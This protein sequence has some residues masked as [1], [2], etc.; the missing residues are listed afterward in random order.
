MSN[1]VEGNVSAAD[2]SSP[3]PRSGKAKTVYLIRHAES[4]ENRRLQAL[5][6]LFTFRSNVFGGSGSSLYSDIL[7]SLSLLDVYS[8]VDTPVSKHGQQQISSISKQVKS[9]NFVTASKVEL[10]VHSPLLRA[11]DTARGMFINGDPNE[12]PFRI[13]EL[14]MIR[15]KY[16][17]EWIPGNTYKL[18]DRIRDFETW[19]DDQQ[20]SVVVV[21][22]H[23]QYFRTMLQVPFKFSNCDVWQAQYQVSSVGSQ[24]GSQNDVPA[25]RWSGLAPVFQCN[26]ESAA[27]DPSPSTTE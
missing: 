16:P 24:E 13:V 3:L 15:E 6:R 5:T 2:D 8:Q 11:R 17:S 18:Y 19:L 7:D 4:E 25:G 26:V 20:E 27:P 9:R 21:V 22:G 10:L 12:E 14:D 1:C 23:S